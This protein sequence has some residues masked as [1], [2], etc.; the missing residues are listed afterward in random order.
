[1]TWCMAA[2][3]QEGSWHGGEGGCLGLAQGR[4][5]AHAHLAPWRA[6][7]SCVRSRARTNPRSTACG[8]Q[9][10]AWGGDGDGGTAGAAGRAIK[11]GSRSKQITCPSLKPPPQR[12]SD[13][14]SATLVDCFGPLFTP[15][16]ALQAFFPQQARAGGEAADE[17]AAG[18]G[19]WR[20]P[21]PCRSR[22]SMCRA[23][24][25]CWGTTS[26]AAART[27]ARGSRPRGSRTCVWWWYKGSLNCRE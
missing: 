17:R 14:N 10:A 19:G 23:R 26:R 27:S 5:G 4:A 7:P 2:W 6:P 20:A 3:W 16:A 25:T 9:G 11:R 12:W 8:W 18:W 1:M 22:G 15:P 13:F 21:P 24:C